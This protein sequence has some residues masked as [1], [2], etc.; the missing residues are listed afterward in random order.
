M[1]G[2]RLRFLVSSS[3]LLPPV[4]RWPIPQVK[5]CI[6]FPIPPC[7]KEWSIMLDRHE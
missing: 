7:L 2:H 5:H 6:L 4:G 3:A 1:E